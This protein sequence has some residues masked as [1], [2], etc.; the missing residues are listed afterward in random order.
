MYSEEKLGK[1][2]FGKSLYYLCNFSVN[3]NYSKIKSLL[4][5]SGARL[6]E[7]SSLCVMVLQGS[8]HVKQLPLT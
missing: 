5:E 3:Q 1:G 6:Y 2:V 4:K 8:E 7:F